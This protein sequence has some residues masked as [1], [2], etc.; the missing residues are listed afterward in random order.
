MADRSDYLRQLQ[1]QL[2]VWAQ[3]AKQLE[4]KALASAAQ[5]RGD[6]EVN[7][8]HRAK[9]LADL[10]AQGRGHLESVSNVTEDAWRD[11]GATAEQTWGSLQA[12]AAALAQQVQETISKPAPRKAASSKKPAAK[13]AAPKKAARKSPAAKARKKAAGKKKVAA[14][15]AK[16]SAARKK[17][18]R[19]AKALVGRAKARRGKAVKKKVAAK[20]KVVRRKVAKA[21]RKPA[22]KK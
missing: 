20:A 6:A 2:N 18:V 14:V 10:I 11:I 17:V 13:K 12:A 21:A 1:E 5:M 15:K 19:K 4:D 9:Q 7:Y 22:R 3:W 16:V 8:E